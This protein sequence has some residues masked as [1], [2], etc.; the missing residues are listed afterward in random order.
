MSRKRIYLIKNEEQDSYID[1]AGRVQIDPKFKYPAAFSTIDE[2][3]IFI[4]NQLKGSAE[5]KK[6]KFTLVK[7]SPDE[8][9]STFF[10]DKLINNFKDL[11][12]LR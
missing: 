3:L 7:F 10:K 9:F 5:E 8:Y 11:Q 12:N 4:E 1:I 2:A 6:K